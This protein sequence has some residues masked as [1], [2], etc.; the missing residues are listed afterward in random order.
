MGGTGAY[1]YVPLYLCLSRVYSPSSLSTGILSRILQLPSSSAR[2]VVHEHVTNYLDTAEECAALP[3]RLGQRTH[4]IRSGGDRFGTG[5]GA[6]T[7]GTQGEQS[8]HG[9]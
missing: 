8:V 5:N 6:A 2:L 1:K 3:A 7:P 9:G 4:G